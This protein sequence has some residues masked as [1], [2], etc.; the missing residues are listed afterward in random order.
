MYLI[1]YP[2]NTLS[3]GTSDGIYEALFTTDMHRVSQ[4][5]EKEKHAKIYRLSD[6][7]EVCEMKI[8]YEE[9]TKETRDD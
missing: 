2:R 8:S 1:L 3:Q 5:L 6:L 4:V 7:T 9:V